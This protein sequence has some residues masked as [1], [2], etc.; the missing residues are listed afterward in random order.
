MDELFVRDPNVIAAVVEGKA[1]LLNLR[2]WHYLSLNETGERIW[3]H[4]ADPQS[5]RELLGLLLEEFDAPEAV[6][7]EDLDRFLGELTEQGC[8]IRP[9]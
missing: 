3:D 8:V 1:M 2:T 9:Q 4:L 6:L 5:R 7:A